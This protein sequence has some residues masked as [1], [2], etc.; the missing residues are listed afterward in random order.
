MRV[1]LKKK[2]KYVKKQTVFRKERN[3]KTRHKNRALMFN[4]SS[5]LERYYEMV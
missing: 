4:L 3:G 1:K 2:P 5:K